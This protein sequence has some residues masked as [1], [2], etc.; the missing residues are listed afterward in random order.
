MAARR[1]FHARGKKNP[2]LWVPALQAPIQ[3]VP[4]TPLHVN[5]VSGTNWERQSTSVGRA[6]C[7]RI[8][9]GL[10][11]TSDEALTGSFVAN[12][13]VVRVGEG[14]FDPTT[15]AAYQTEQIMWSSNGTFSASQ[16]A[17]LNYEIDV[18][19]RRRLTNDS[20]VILSFG[21]TTLNLLV[22]F[23]TRSL[24]QVG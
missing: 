9:G 13:R 3:V 2:M 11:V 16:I 10:S 7:L 4:G 20:I 8:R 18:K 15:L 14:L 17:T 1:R 12:I 21:T 24:I 23:M 5:L 19:A 6:T 22:G